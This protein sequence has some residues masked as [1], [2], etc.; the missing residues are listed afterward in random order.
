[1]RAVVMRN[2]KLVVDNIPAPVLGP[3]DVLVKTLACGICGTDLHALKFAETLVAGS[4][5]SGGMF[6]I[7]PSRNIVMGHE[8][9][10]EVVDYGPKTRK[11]FKVGTHVCSMPVVIRSTG[12]EYIGYSS[13]HPG[14]FGE[15]MRLT[16]TN[17]IEVPSDL[18]PEV[19]A[20]TEPLAVG[21][22]AV[23]MARLG[24]HDVSLVMGCGPVGLSII[25]ALKLSGAEPIVAADF[26]PYRR[27]LAVKMGADIAIDPREKSPY[28]TFTS[29]GS[30]SRPAAIFECVGVSGML[31]QIMANAPRHTKIIVAGLCMERDNIYTMSGI[32][33]ELNLQFVLGYNRDEFER[34]FRK[35]RKGKLRVEPL[36]TGK[37]GV[38]G[39]AKAFEDLS[40]PGQHAKIIV[41]PWRS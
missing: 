24:R 25:A 14:G 28:E 39:V 13:E 16:E 26:S 30:A 15:M 19:A 8:F 1:M 37:V 31:D 38:K 2:N 11:R 20:L 3:G 40:S 34:A 4:P 7:D 6:A 10:G 29:D 21:F 33:K 9:C 23:A 22:H 5:S 41:E 27:E 32:H 36:I 12:D 17:L 35:I 18:P